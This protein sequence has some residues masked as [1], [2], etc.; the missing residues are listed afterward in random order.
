M[1]HC[2]TRTCTRRQEV[3]A[4][5]FNL[6][7]ATQGPGKVLGILN[8]YISEAVESLRPC[9]NLFVFFIGH[10]SMTLEGFTAMATPKDVIL[11]RMVLTATCLKVQ[12]F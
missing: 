7:P 1:F 4:K 6:D 10:A 3:H 9:S 2:R 12:G 8:R 5:L 11:E